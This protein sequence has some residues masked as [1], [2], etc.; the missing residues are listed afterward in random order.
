MYLEQFLELFNPLPGNHY[1]E[2]TT[3]IDALSYAL[4]ELMD[5][6]EGSFEVVL[7]AQE[8]EPLNS[9]KIKLQEIKSLHNPFRALPR[10][11]DVVVLKDIFSRHQNKEL[12]LRI[13][14]TT[15]AN[16]AEI[17]IVEPKGI[18]DIE[19]TKLLLEKFEFRV[20]NAMD[21]LDG[22]DVLTA[23]KM[24]MWGNGL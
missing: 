10:N 12:L 8:S 18:L 1:L 16:T 22:Y 2:V 6:V 11:H 17:V 5:G 23:K 20:P 13:A 9:T 24:H 4:S 19:A 21:I 14:Y 15:L 3:K 7:Y